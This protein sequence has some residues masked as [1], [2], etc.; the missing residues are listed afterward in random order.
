VGKTLRIG[1]RDYQVTGVV[2]NVPGN[3]HFY[4]DVIIS[5]TSRGNYRNPNW[6]NNNYHT[7]ANVQKD[8]PIRQFESILE[9]L[10][11]TNIKPTLTRWEN[12]WWKYELEPL[13]KIHLH[14]ELNGPYGVSGKAEYVYIFTIIAFFH[15]AYCLC[16]LC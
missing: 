7:Y 9:G 4:F 13:L 6:L 16:K 11:E 2:E 5:L 1:S 15:P 10:V 14:S 8:F 3:S 12:N